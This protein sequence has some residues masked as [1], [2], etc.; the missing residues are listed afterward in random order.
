[1]EVRSK[2]VALILLLVLAAVLGG[3][4]YVFTTEVFVV[5]AGAGVWWFALV[6]TVI[7]ALATASAL[8]SGFHGEATSERIALLLLA[9]TLTVAAVV[10]GL[11]F[12]PFN[13]DNI[14]LGA[15]LGGTEL[16]TADTLGL[17]DAP[18]DVS[19]SNVMPAVANQGQCNSCWAF[20]AAAVLSARQNMKTEW[21][22]ND[23]HAPVFPSCLGYTDLA[24]IDNSGWR[25]SPQSLIDL[26]AYKNGAG[27][28][29]GSYGQQ[30]LLLAARPGGVP[31]AAC[32]PSFSSSSPVCATACGSPMSTLDGKL[33]CTHATSVDWTSCPVASSPG[34]SA[35]TR[36][37][38]GP[39]F[40]IVGEDALK[41][42]VA[43]H[44]PVICLVNFYAKPDGAL[45]GWTLADTVSVFG[46]PASSLTSPA[47]V[48]RPTSDG[49]AYTKSFA[50]GAHAVTVHGFG[51]SA[52][53]VP[54]WH[55]RNSWGAQWGNKGDTK[56]ERGVDAWNIESY[57]YAATT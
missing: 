42:E 31:G 7:A 44:G 46:G 1:M 5:K 52:A 28:C 19:W 15:L 57:C 3:I 22:S 27:K 38:A 54:Y 16:E 6:L 41:R 34:A 48:A 33:V 47:Y 25:V 24:R 37:V 30:G 53:G 10:L 26:D 2:L 17:P 50:G 23:D 4:F 49:T 12:Q 45:A 43:A 40:R 39:A 55:I 18:P 35:S 21:R 51:T 8:T 56:I 13:P 14:R 11:V 29:I 9:I 20:A 32:V 36:L